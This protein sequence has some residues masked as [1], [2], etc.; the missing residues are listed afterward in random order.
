MPWNIKS[1]VPMSCG[2]DDLELYNLQSQCSTKKLWNIFAYRNEYQ[3]L[4]ICITYDTGNKSVPRCVYGNRMAKILPKMRSKCGLH[5]PNNWTIIPASM[6]IFPRAIIVIYCYLQIKTF[7]NYRSFHIQY[8]LAIN[9][10][11]TS[12]TQQGREHL[13]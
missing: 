7:Q 2:M 4:G 6:L 10:F 1:A 8:Y 9:Y 11:N 3:L 13:M 12:Y 5:D